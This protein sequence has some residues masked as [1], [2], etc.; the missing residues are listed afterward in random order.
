VS[1]PKICN[2]QTSGIPKSSLRNP[3]YTQ[4]LTPTFTLLYFRLKGS[5]FII[6][7]L[8]QPSS[9]QCLWHHGFIHSCPS[10][11]DSF[12]SVFH[13]QTSNLQG[14]AK[15]HSVVLSM[16]FRLLSYPFRLLH[17]TIRF[18][19]FVSALNYFYQILEEG[20]G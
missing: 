7:Y 10:F 13:S 18:S 9:L 14:L 2:P 15:L 8:T 4:L 12:Y 16:R 19:H 1:I 20:E 6:L 3:E 5:T 11:G 17:R